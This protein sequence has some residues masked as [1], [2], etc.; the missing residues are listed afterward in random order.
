MD[1]AFFKVLTPTEV[2]A[3]QEYARTH[4]PNWDEWDIYHPIC[5]AEWIRLGKGPR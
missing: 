2:I 1:D 5:R 3:F 4:E